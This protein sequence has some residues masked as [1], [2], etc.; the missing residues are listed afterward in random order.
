MQWILAAKIDK[1]K[2]RE[3][4]IWHS[5]PCLLRW[6]RSSSCV[7]LVSSYTSAANKRQKSYPSHK[8]I[9]AF[10]AH[11]YMPRAA[12]QSLQVANISNW[13]NRARSRIA[14][15][16]ITAPAVSAKIGQARSTRHGFYLVPP[17]PQTEGS[18][19][20]PP[21]SWPPSPTNRSTVSSSSPRSWTQTHSSCECQPIRQ[22]IQLKTRPFDL[23]PPPA[24][25]SR[26]TSWIWGDFRPP[27]RRER[28]GEGK[29]RLGKRK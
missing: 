19:R 7:L 18:A 8:K 13:P 2:P 9:P 12:N 4:T 11:N 10:V 27:R 3:A 26:E 24:D 21:S 22:E 6:I 14:N 1:S 16:T 17:W 5:I 25:L 15:K 20:A 29:S 28:K 23:S